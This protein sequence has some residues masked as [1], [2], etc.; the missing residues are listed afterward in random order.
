M[1]IMRMLATSMVALALVGAPLSAAL[2]GEVKGPPGTPD[3]TN[4][5]AAPTHSNSACS[6]SGLNDM[7]SA[8]GQTSSQVQTAALSPIS[9]NLSVPPV[10]ASHRS[11]ASLSPVAAELTVPAVTASYAQTAILAPVAVSLTVPAPST[12][13]HVTAPLSPFDSHRSTRRS[14]R[15]CRSRC[16]CR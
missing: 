5:T 8:D 13:Y 10:S 15:T 7:D 9:V 11:A 3:N 4:E 2:A 6:Y 1:I 12:A 16:H 14:E